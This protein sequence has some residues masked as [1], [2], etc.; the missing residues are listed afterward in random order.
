LDSF[1]FECHGLEEWWNASGKNMDLKLMWHPW[2]PKNAS[3]IAGALIPQ[4]LLSSCSQVKGMK[5]FNI[6]KLPNL[7]WHRLMVFHLVNCLTLMLIVSLLVMDTNCQLVMLVRFICLPPLNFA[8][9]GSC[10]FLILNI[11]FYL[12]NTL[13]SK[14]ILSL[15]LMLFYMC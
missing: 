10:M 13:C 3:C 7:T 14:I 5:R 8:L 15:T 2:D 11:V 6:L 9:P 12:L 4:M 1:I